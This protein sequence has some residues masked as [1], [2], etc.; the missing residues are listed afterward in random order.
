ME[1]TRKIYTDGFDEKI[2]QFDS[3]SNK[4]FFHTIIKNMYNIDATV[5]HFDHS[6]LP[7]HQPPLGLSDILILERYYWYHNEKPRIVCVKCSVV[8]IIK[9]LFN[10]DLLHTDYIYINNSY[11][12]KNK[13]NVEINLIA[14]N[15]M[16]FLSNLYPATPCNCDVY[17]VEVP[18]RNKDIVT[19]SSIINN[20]TCFNN[21]IYGKVGNVMDC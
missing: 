3:K 9:Q 13:E 19:L 14:V 16:L 5:Y 1:Q 15:P 4:D 20:N 8:N 21:K 2:K 18:Y 17:C 12:Y 7:R 6:K 10:N 11:N